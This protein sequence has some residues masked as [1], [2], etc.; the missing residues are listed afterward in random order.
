MGF[1]YQVLFLSGDM[2]KC[3]RHHS[4]LADISALCVSSCCHGILWR[5][6]RRLDELE[7]APGQSA[8]SWQTVSRSGSQRQHE[9]D[10]P[11]AVPGQNSTSW[12]MVSAGGGEV[13]G[14]RRRWDKWSRQAYCSSK[15]RQGGAGR[16]GDPPHGGKTRQ[17]DIRGLGP[18]IC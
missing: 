13:I 7:A 15:A 1:C 8:G 12:R 18:G 10:N 17:R 16:T 14:W 3:N 9:E 6:Q 5:S 11:E 4:I 2:N